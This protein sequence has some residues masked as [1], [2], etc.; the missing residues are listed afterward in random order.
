VYSDLANVYSELDRPADAERTV[1]QALSLDPEHPI[2]LGNL[3]LQLVRQRKFAAAE[4]AI[5]KVRARAPDNPVQLAQHAF[6]VARLGKAPEA[7]ALLD[8]AERLGVSR[9]QLAISYLVLGDTART[10]ALLER[11][12][13]EGDDALGLLLDST[14]FVPLRGDARFRRLVSQVRGD[15]RQP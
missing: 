11:G 3:A 15:V 9:V 2:L 5:V 8:T 7:R 1:R 13:R 12:V 6:V 10:F 4:S 14:Y